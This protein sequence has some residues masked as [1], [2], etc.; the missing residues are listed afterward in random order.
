MAV[1]LIGLVDPVGARYQLE[2]M[3]LEVPLEPELAQHVD[4]SFATA[5]EVKVLADH[6]DRRIQAIDQDAANEMAR[7][8][9]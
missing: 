5:A 4:V 6:H 2:R 1:E 9:T 8:F 3:H 7:V